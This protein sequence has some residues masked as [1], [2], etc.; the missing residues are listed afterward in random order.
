[1]NWNAGE[2][3][4]VT[5]NSRQCGK[6]Q[7]MKEIIERI[8]ERTLKYDLDISVNEKLR[9]LD[10]ASDELSYCESDFRDFGENSAQTSHVADYEHWKMTNKRNKR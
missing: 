2:Y 6:T 5:I 3:R 10:R 7:D 8:N 9:L 1:M 4:T